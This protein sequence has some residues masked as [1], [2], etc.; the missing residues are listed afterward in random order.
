MIAFFSLFK[1]REFNVYLTIP[2]T[3]GFETAL[4]LCKCVNQINSVHACV[5]VFQTNI[6]ILWPDTFNEIPL[7]KQNIWH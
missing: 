7:N 2:F 1:E 6:L 4:M 3:N 5:Y